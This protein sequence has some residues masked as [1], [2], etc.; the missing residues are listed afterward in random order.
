MGFN[1]TSTCFTYLENPQ[2]AIQKVSI[3]Y[4]ISVQEASSILKR[5]CANIL[6][7]DQYSNWFGNKVKNSRKEDVARGKAYAKHDDFRSSTTCEELEEDMST[8]NAD[9]DYETTNLVG[10]KK[11]ATKEGRRKIYGL[12]QVYKDVDSRYREMEC[13]EEGEEMRA[14]EEEAMLS[15]VFTKAEQSRLAIKGGTNMTTYIAI[16]VGVLVLAGGIMIA[17]KKSKNK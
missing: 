3:E 14:A 5:K 7:D 11:K 8:L 4:G 13:S 12:N 10:A 17:I 15:D 2:L 1:L 9:I 6:D 16:G